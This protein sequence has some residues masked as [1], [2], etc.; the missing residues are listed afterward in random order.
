VVFNL[1]VYR[2]QDWYVLNVHRR[3]RAGGSHRR[4]TALVRAALQAL[5]AGGAA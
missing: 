2:R 1:A 5:A 4:R 3:R